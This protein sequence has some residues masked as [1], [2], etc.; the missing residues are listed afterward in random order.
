MLTDVLA[1]LDRAGIA[2]GP[3]TGVALLA[4][5]LLALGVRI[6]NYQV[7]PALTNDPSYIGAFWVGVLAALGSDVAVLTSNR[8]RPPGALPRRPTGG[9]PTSACLVLLL[10]SLRADGR[11]LHAVAGPQRPDSGD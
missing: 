4:L 1:R 6:P 2:H 8:Y 10:P 9:S 5:G 7:V 3:P 11:A